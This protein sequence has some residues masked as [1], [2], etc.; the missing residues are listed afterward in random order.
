M[1]LLSVKPG[2]VKV[3]GRSI[4]ISPEI[5]ESLVM[6]LYFPYVAVSGFMVTEPPYAR[7]SKGKVKTLESELFVLSYTKDPIAESP[8]TVG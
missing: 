3:N 6:K 4:K 8:M 1:V 7:L 2:V 5:F